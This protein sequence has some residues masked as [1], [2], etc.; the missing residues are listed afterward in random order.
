MNNIAKLFTAACLLAVGV[1]NSGC[2]KILDIDSPVNER[3]TS[4]V[5]SSPET[6]RAALS[7][8]YS[9]L[10]SSQTY[11]LNMTVANALAADELRAVASPARYAPLF[12]NSYN[13]ITSSSTADM[14]NDSYVS[15][16]RFNAIIAGLSNNTAISESVSRQLIAEA[17][18]MRGYLYM[19]LVAL[20]GDAPL[21][22][23]T[24][25]EIT[26]TLPRTAATSVYAQIIQDLTEAKA[27]LSDAYPSNAGV[28]NRQQVNKAAAT[29]M[30]A[31]AYLATG[32]WQEASRNAAEVIA[33]TGLYRLLP[34]DR[35]SDV[36]LANS[37]EAI[38]QL[39]S[40]L[41]ATSG[42]TNEGQSLQSGPF[43]SASPFSLTQNLL[44]SF[45]AGDLRREAWVRTV[46][47]R[48]ITAYEPYKYRNVDT[49]AATA[50]GREELPTILRLA[51]MYLVRAEANLGLGN[52]QAAL[53]DLNLIRRRAGLS[54]PL[55]SSI[56]VALAIEHERQI[57]LFCERGD[58]WLTLKR[59]GRVNTVMSAAKPDT[60]R[61]FAQFFPIPQT[62]MDSNP[63]L[64]QNQGY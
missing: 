12:T 2:K 43:S 44:A 59:T 58:R 23:T 18:A 7:G 41:N 24:N 25:V 21:V 50:A 54:T 63:N 16:Y 37:T 56:N 53:D 45:E 48:G 11:A 5:F 36:F 22:L 40:A 28:S 26:A 15:I 13:A 52:V 6:A 51:D 27:A 32:N 3:P 61:S 60:W 55:T 14:W 47:I 8:A 33:N 20:F 35:L 57:E 49:D 17:K 38:L 31:K 1:V 30:L 62:A 64:I 4:V 46:T 10:S 19:Q 42:Y 39:G 9:N 29:A 34:G